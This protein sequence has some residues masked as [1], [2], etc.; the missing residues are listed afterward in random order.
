MNN[1]L[2]FI[3]FKKFLNK[4]NVMLFDGE[5]RIAHYK[6]IEIIKLLG[7]SGGSNNL[8][9]KNNSKFLIN[10]IK[11]HGENVLRIFTYSLVENNINKINYI[12]EL[13]N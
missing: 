7:Q 1:H 5:Y 6:Y 10:K 8:S 12:L 4:S 2:E 3:E 11:N 13:L 9:D